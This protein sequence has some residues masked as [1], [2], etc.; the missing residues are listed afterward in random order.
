MGKLLMRTS[1]V[2]YSY[3]GSS[4]TQI[5]TD[6]VGSTNAPGNYPNNKLF[7]TDDGSLFALP[8]YTFYHSPGVYKYDF[9]N[10]KWSWIDI[11][12]SS[13]T[14]SAQYLVGAVHKNVF[15]VFSDFNPMFFVSEDYGNTW[16]EYTP[17]GIGGGYVP[18]WMDFVEG[19][20]YC[21]IRSNG[22]GLCKVSLTGA[23]SIIIAHGA[24][25]SSHIVP[26]AGKHYY[27]WQAGGG[28]TTLNLSEIDPISG[29]TSVVS[30]FTSSGN[31][32]YQVLLYADKVG[33]RLI[34]GGIEVTTGAK[35]AWWTDS[36]LTTF[37]QDNTIL[38]NVTPQT[39]VI[40]DW[41]YFNNDNFSNALIVRGHDN[42]FDLFSYDN[43]TNKFIAEISS[44]GK[45][46]ASIVE[47]DV[48]LPSV[49][50][51]PKSVNTAGNRFTLNLKKWKKDSL[52]ISIDPKFSS[53]KG[54]TFSSMTIDEP[55]TGVPTAP[56]SVTIGTDTNAFNDDFSKDLILGY[57][58]YV[59]HSSKGANSTAVVDTANNLLKLTA[60]N[61]ESISLIR[62]FILLAGDF[63]V[64]L[65]FNGVGSSL[66]TSPDTVKAGLRCRVLSEPD[67]NN[68]KYYSNLN[69]VE[70]YVLKDSANAG[71]YQAN[72]V[73]AGTSS[74]A[75]GAAAPTIGEDPGFHIS[76]A[77]GLLQ[78]GYSSANTIIS[79][80][81]PLNYSGAMIVE[82]FVDCTGNAG[83]VVD[84]K[85][86]H[87]ISGSIQFEGCVTSEI[88]WNFAADGILQDSKIIAKVIANG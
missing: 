83:Q 22:Y 44:T 52:S 78:C 51:D 38:D 48:N 7:K 13:T 33:G 36:T 84:F 67:V 17:S 21:V 16:V 11:P 85:N 40:G 31:G 41:Q 32:W 25:F 59:Y 37:T 55:K 62:R 50:L 2:V 75:N 70:M 30:S 61:G 29:S 5:G 3:D 54:Y 79:V 45:G 63:H 81:A 34:V 46:M 49:G 74:T 64:A 58:G 43:T 35:N 76:R 23:A 73:V 6:V 19:Q 9:I 57:D 68:R 69:Y 10:D 15:V 87:L 26:F 47:Y 20:L 28:S 39:N 66:T 8:N 1:S 60:F 88:N 24:V 56:P 82:I 53:N 72:H 4:L 80:G 27:A 65:G 42:G 14:Y 18:V 86:L 12:G 77:S 71:L